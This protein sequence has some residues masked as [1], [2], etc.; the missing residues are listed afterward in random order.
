VD[1]IPS[2]RRWGPAGGSGLD[3]DR[4][5]AEITEPSDAHRSHQ[6]LPSRRPGWD[7]R[8]TFAGTRSVMTMD[9]GVLGARPSQGRVGDE[10]DPRNVTLPHDPHRPLLVGT[11]VLPDTVRPRTRRQ[12]LPVFGSGGAA[13]VRHAT[14]SRA[15]RTTVTTTAVHSPRASR[16]ASLARPPRGGSIAAGE[17]PPRGKGVRAA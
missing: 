2:V 17:G 10:H 6:A 3:Q 4:E 12:T 14:S 5:V 1:A 13:K 16:N 8:R 11:S 15:T 9:R 7:P